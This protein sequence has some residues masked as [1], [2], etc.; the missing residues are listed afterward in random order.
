MYHICFLR[1]MLSVFS[2]YGAY[3]K[4]SYYAILVLID[5]S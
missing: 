5:V 4:I 1:V 2:G 3:L